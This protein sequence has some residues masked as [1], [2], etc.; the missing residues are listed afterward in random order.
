LATVGGPN[1]ATRIATWNAFE[2]ALSSLNA[3]RQDA[4]TTLKALATAN[5]DAPVF[6]TTYARALKDAG[7]VMPALAA[8]R[9]AARRWP[10]DATL[11]HDLAVAAREAAHGTNGSAARARAT[12]ATRAEQAAA[13]RRPA[14]RLRI[15][16]LAWRPSTTA[17]GA[18]R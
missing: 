12:G 9:Q 4:L 8:Y 5:P 18:R 11:I 17:A 16:A 13:A 3:H 1:P 10:T 15:T 14:P 2:E 6:Q 7:Q